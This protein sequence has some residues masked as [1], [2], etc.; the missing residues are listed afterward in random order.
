MNK[1]CLLNYE[2]N[3]FSFHLIEVLQQRTCSK[4]VP[5]FIALDHFGS[6]VLVEE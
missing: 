2:Q 4:V 5:Y 6:R 1:L 3:E